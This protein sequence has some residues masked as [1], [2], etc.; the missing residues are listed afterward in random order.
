[1]PQ[2]L[3]WLIIA[4]VVIAIIIAVV[5][6]T[7]RRKQTVNRERAGELREQAAAQAT[8]VQ[9]R[10]AHAQETEAAAAA[11]R[12]EADRKQAEAQRL[13][14]EAEE[15]RR[16]AEGYRSEHQETLQRADELDPDVNTRSDEY[17]GPQG[18]VPA[19]GADQGTTEGTTG[20]TTAGGTTGGTTGDAQTV[21]HPDGSTETVA[22]P[23][24]QGA[25]RVTPEEGSHR[26]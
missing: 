8:G 18:A 16:T 19:G 20:G 14:A 5:A 3:I 15:R 24:A 26:A 22:D 13:E 17:A 25:E 10:H 2:W 6:A 7:R 12:A 1:M 4:V 9:Q 23:S 21:T 11:A